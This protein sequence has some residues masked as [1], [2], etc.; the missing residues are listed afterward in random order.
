MP[1]FTKNVQG[2][3]VLFKIL[4]GLI[5]FAHPLLSGSTEHM[6][7]GLRE[8][9]TTWAGERTRCVSEVFAFPGI[10]C[11]SLTPSDGTCRFMDVV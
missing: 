3:N 4:G 7:P 2:R 6:P 11:Q 9:S 10:S 1:G 5:E 8:E